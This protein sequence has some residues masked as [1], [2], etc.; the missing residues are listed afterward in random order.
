MKIVVAKEIDPSEPRVAA[1][2]DTVKKFVAL[3]AEIAVRCARPNR[4]SSSV[5]LER[6]SNLER[7]VAAP[8]TRGT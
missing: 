4:S 8:R 6:V 7:I 3:G 2:P 5:S 1:S